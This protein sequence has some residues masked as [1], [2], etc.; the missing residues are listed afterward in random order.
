MDG[1]QFQLMAEPAH[2]H[3]GETA[4]P[5]MW[6]LSRKSTNRCGVSLVLMPMLGRRQITST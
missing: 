2:G 4:G 3:T 6:P 1:P 5:W